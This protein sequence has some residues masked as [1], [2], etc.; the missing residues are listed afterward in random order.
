M[1][2]PLKPIQIDIA[3]QSQQPDGGPESEY[4]RRGKCLW[5]FTMKGQGTLERGKKGK[6]EDTIGPHLYT[7]RMVRCNRSAK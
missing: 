6:L 5:I 1:F 4:H 7:Q 2:D 3:S